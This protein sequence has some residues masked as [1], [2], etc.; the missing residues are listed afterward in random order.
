MKNFEERE[1][2]V[3]EILDGVRDPDF[4]DAK[5]KIAHYEI[6]KVVR[7]VYYEGCDDGIQTLSDIQARN[8][9]IINNLFK[10]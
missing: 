10:N 8:Q 7:E 9:E 6:M 4:F 1:K 2:Q 5:L 3:Q